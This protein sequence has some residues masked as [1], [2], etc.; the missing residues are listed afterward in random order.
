MCQLDGLSYHFCWIDCDV[1]IGSIHRR[2]SLHFFVFLNVP[3]QFRNAKVWIEQDRV[4]SCRIN[5]MWMTSSRLKLKNE[6]W[7]TQRFMLC[8]E[9][10]YIFKFW[11][12]SFLDLERKWEK[13]MDIINQR[14]VG[15]V[16]EASVSRNFSR[17]ILENQ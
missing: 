11:N 9:L 15:Q 8:L 10:W 5:R 7:R 4:Q 13:Q 3:D 14:I 16:I 17:K 1:L 2:F 12:F 6:M